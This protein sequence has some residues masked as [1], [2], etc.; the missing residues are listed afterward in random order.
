MIFKLTK[1]I[2]YEDNEYEELNL[3]LEGLKCYDLFQV[4][5]LGRTLDKERFQLWGTR[6]IMLLAARAAGINF[7]AMYEVSAK[8]FLKIQVAI[9]NFFSDV[10]S[11]ESTRDSSEAP[12]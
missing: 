11:P 6:H 10:I 1:K 2:F 9:I 7:L 12:F 8:D 4:E 3:D 5:D